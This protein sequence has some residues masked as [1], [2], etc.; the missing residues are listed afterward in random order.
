MNHRSGNTTLHGARWLAL[1]LVLLLMSGTQL[2]NALSVTFTTDTT[3]DTGTTTYEGYDVIVHGATVTIN[4]T[5]SFNSLTVES[6]GLVTHA[7]GL[8]GGL[9]LSIA[10]TVTINSGSSISADGCGYAAGQGA[11]AEGASRSPMI[12]TRSRAY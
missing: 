8:V 5:H 9:S 3:I 11:E 1:L 2:A 12:R 7:Q 4:G 10:T 6:N